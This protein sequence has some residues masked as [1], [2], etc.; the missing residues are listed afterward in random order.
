MSAVGQND[1]RFE[2]LKKEVQQLGREEAMGDD[3]LPKLALKVVRAAA[4]GVIDL[5]KN[6]H[7][8]G[9]DDATLLYTGYVEAKGKKSIHE[10]T[11]AGI[12]S[13]VSKLRQGIT[14]GMRTTCDAVAN[15][16]RAVVIRKQLDDAGEKVKPAYAAYVDVWRA[17]NEQDGDLTDEQIKDAVRK[18][19]TAEKDIEKVLK[20]IQNTLE[21]LIAGEYKTGGTVLK[22]QD[23]RTIQAFEHIRERLAALMTEVET[24]DILARAAALGLAVT[25][26]GNATVN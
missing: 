1:M 19:P 14:A 12:K 3:A 5:D 13:N 4:D 20:P 24:Q 18:K 15:T 23:P 26:P 9:V 22:D 11:P 6:K 17:L 25:A 21:K 10:H 16:D 2:D 8:P 7:G